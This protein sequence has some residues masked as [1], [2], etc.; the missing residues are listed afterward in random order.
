MN[1]PDSLQN[2]V[3]NTKVN[4]FCGYFTSGKSYSP[5]R[6]AKCIDEF[7][8][9]HE[10]YGR[11]PTVEE[12]MAV[13]KTGGSHLGLKLWRHCKYNK[14]LSIVKKGHRYAGPLSRIESIKKGISL[15]LYLLYLDWC[16]RPICSYQHEIKAKYGI[17]V[18]AGTISKWFNQ[19]KR[20]KDVFVKLTCAFSDL[21][22][23]EENVACYKLFTGKII[24]SMYCNN[25]TFADE[26][27][28]ILND[29][30][31]LRIRKDP[32][33]GEVP[34]IVYGSG[35]NTRKRHNIFY[36]IRP[37]NN[38]NSNKTLVYVITEKIAQQSCFKTALY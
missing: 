26:K 6:L 10:N 15:D 29:L 23:T 25:I 21:K 37:F 24:A 1:N 5:E 27:L 20:Y 32:I 13:S 16:N 7:N 33:I 38:S 11:Y 34:N 36:T 22:Y 8:D 19:N 17:N 30:L 28:F 3:N 18:S 14:A 4:R 2:R 35:V 31:K 12:F 9:F